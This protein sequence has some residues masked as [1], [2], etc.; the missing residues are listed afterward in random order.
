[1][2]FHL[3]CSEAPT[4]SV[5]SLQTEGFSSGTA[6]L[7]CVSSPEKTHPPFKK[8]QTIFTKELNETDRLNPL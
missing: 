3:P 5:L 7:H 8:E 6:Q 1:M 4:P 2:L